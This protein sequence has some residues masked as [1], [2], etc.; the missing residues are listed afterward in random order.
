[1][2]VDGCCSISYDDII[3]LQSESDKNTTFNRLSPTQ[4]FV[5]LKYIYIYSN[6]AREGGGHRQRPSHDTAASTVA[7]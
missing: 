1:M 5:F 7:E 6:I 4:L 2:C 3:T